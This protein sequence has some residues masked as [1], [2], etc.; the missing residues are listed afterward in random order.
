[1]PSGTQSTGELDGALASALDG[2][3]GG[4]NT[5]S[6]QARTRMLMNN[7]G[8]TIEEVL[9]SMGF[10]KYN[11]N[12]IAEYYR[13]KSNLLK[14]AAFLQYGGQEEAIDPV[15]YISFARDFLTSLGGNLGSAK[16]RV[17][18]ALG[19]KGTQP[20]AWKSMLSGGDTDQYGNFNPYLTDQER[21]QWVN[22]LTSIGQMGYGG[23]MAQYLLSNVSRM[24][25]EFTTGLGTGTIPEN[26]DFMD[27]IRNNLTKFLPG[28]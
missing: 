1:M 7:P 16:D 3:S 15:D 10:G 8:G 11:T 20:D 19:I 13:G 5:G 12:P 2:G 9:A 23:P 27:Y 17:L 26:T 4:F 6:N 18:E 25:P 22:A 21:Q 14:P 24:A 28:W